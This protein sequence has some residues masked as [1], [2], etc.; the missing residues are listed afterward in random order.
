M[1]TAFDSPTSSP[2]AA[3]FHDDAFLHLDGSAAAADAFP[4][5]PD[6]YAPSPFGMPQANGGL[7]D[8]PFHSIVRGLPDDL[9][10]GLLLK[11][12]ARTSNRK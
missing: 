12:A 11:H 5:S 3:P 7:H 8:D 10:R 2:A 1:A 6:P 4:A 9:L